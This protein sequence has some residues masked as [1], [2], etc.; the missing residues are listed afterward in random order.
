MAM[1]EPLGEGAGAQWPEPLRVSAAAEGSRVRLLRRRLAQWLRGHHL[2]E[3]VVEDLV[4]AA[5][6]ALEN[7]CDHAF[8]Q[9]SSAGTMSLSA[10]LVGEA[11]VITVADDGCWQQATAGP[12]QRGRGLALMRELVDEVVIETGPDRDPVSR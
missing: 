12:S 4:L 5:S 2:D 10:R 1:T 11:L 9:S 8:E 6:E 7:C 3:D